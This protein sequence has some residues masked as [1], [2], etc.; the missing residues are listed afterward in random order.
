MSLEALLRRMTELSAASPDGLVR[1]EDISWS[2]RVDRARARIRSSL[3]PLQLALLDDATTWIAA[4]CG[5]QSGKNYTVIR[6]LIDTCL[7]VP[8]ANAVYVNATF[9]EARTIM[10]ADQ[11]DG[12]PAVLRDLGLMDGC[13]LNESRLEVTFPNGSRIEL[14]GADRGAWEKLRGNKFDLVVVD[15][16]Q[17]LEDGGFRNALTRVLPD[18]LVARRGRCVLIGTPDEFCVGVFHAICVG[19]ELRYF[20]HH[21]WDAEHLSG[22]TSVW[23]EQLAWKGLTGT[24]DDDPVWLREKRGLWIRQDSALMLPIGPRGLWTGELPLLIPSRHGPLV[25]RSEAPITYGGVDFGFSGDPSA[26]VCLSVS[27]EE[28]VD[29]EVHSSKHPGLN[30]QQ[31]ADVL[32]GIQ[33]EHGVTRFYG[34]PTSPRSIEDLRTLYG[35]PIVAGEN[36]GKELW[37]QEMRSRLVDGRLRVLEGSPLHAEIGTLSPDPRQLLAKRLSTRPGSDDHCYDA[38]RYVYR[39]IHTN[40]VRAP[41]TPLDP[42]GRREADVM[43]MAERRARELS[44]DVREHDPRSGPRNPVRRHR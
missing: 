31:L 42:I 25:S 7:T 38:F 21:H 36:Q 43:A 15:E 44:H 1:S 9:R 19:A 34:D 24:A 41:E 23:A 39:G 2:D 40:H 32:R 16:C 6:L 20:R 35:I 30:T 14:L 3:V 11:V 8:G 4:S 10:W 26:V 5:R 33:R 18:T 17:K 22:V 27:R 28:G 37:I 13:R 29:R 12:I